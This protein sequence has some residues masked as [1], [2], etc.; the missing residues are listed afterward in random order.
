[1]AN[2]KK[3]NTARGRCWY[4][5]CFEKEIKKALRISINYPATRKYLTTFPLNINPLPAYPADILEQWNC[6]LVL[7]NNHIN[8]AILKHG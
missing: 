3:T 4:P 5:S 6:Y 8:P 7:F 1:M 2:N